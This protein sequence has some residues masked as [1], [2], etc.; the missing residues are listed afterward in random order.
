[1]L[2]LS[3]TF[4]KTMCLCFAVSVAANSFNSL[5]PPPSNRIESRS[6]GPETQ[7]GYSA[8]KHDGKTSGKRAHD[9]GEVDAHDQRDTTDEE[10]A[11]TRPL[12]SK[13]TSKPTS[14]PASKPTKRK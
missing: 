12:K 1:M 3:S 2:R 7:K 4:V 14:K 11:V 6:K 10:S 13:P 9:Q 5:A 8:G